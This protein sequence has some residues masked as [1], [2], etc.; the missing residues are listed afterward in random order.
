MGQP[1][2]RLV[3]RGDPAR[4]IYTLSGALILVTLPLAVLEL[5]VFR[6][7]PDAP[8]AWQPVL[9]I[10]LVAFAL[11]AAALCVTMLVEVIARARGKRATFG[12]STLGG[13]TVE[14]IRS[15]PE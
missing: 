13:R 14:D 9:I 15:R 6:S 2:F 4:T 3:H 8:T 5:L 7:I 11:S 10:T 1:R 12:I